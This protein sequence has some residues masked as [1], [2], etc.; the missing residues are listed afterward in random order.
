MLCEGRRVVQDYSEIFS[1]WMMGEQRGWDDLSSWSWCIYRPCQQICL[2]NSLELNSGAQ[3]AWDS[4]CL[5][6]TNWELL[7]YCNFLHQMHLG[8][9]RG[10]NPFLLCNTSVTPPTTNTSL[11]HIYL[12]YVPALPLN[13]KLMKGKNASLMSE[14]PNGRDNGWQW[15]TVLKVAKSVKENKESR[16]N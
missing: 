9:P 3:N 11:W 12:L 6:D 10:V 16:Q 5:R 4:S 2:T 1:A 7:I 8:A 15:L 13:H 14:P